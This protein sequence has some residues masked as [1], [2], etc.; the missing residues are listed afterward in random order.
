MSRP[1]F[2]VFFLYRSSSERRD[3]A[4]GP[5]AY[6]LCGLDLAREYGL[7]PITDFDRI[8]KVESRSGARIDRWVNRLW[9][10]LGGYGGFWWKVWA[11]RDLIARADVVVSQVDTVGIP[12]LWLMNWR[13]VPRR[14]IVYITVGLRAR[15]EAMS[16][17][18]R[19]K[20]IATAGRLIDSLVCFGYG[21]AQI[22]KQ[23]FSTGKPAVAFVPY[24]VEAL[25]PPEAWLADKWRG[26][27]YLSLG[28]DGNR[29]FDYL[30][31]LA[32]FLDRRVIA[33]TSSSDPVLF[34]R[35]GKL[36]RYD[37]APFELIVELIRGARAIILPVKENEYSGAT[38]ALM[39]CLALGKAV[40]VH[41][42]AAVL[43]GYGLKDGH[44]CVFLGQD[45]RDSLSTTAGQLAD[46]FLL[47]LVG[48]NAKS[49]AID[50]RS[51]AAEILRLAIQAAQ[52]R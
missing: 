37:P 2:K 1:E 49:A 5:E 9:R 47:A 28:N 19:K 32:D 4:G 12:L 50:Y 8:G 18:L 40:F 38:T 46:D 20:F 21:E 42:T 33:V 23:I 34:S 24:G 44:N 43:E 11:D 31:K 45:S 10:L 7:D 6:K 26:D 48:A 22:M 15:L 52:H 30:A 27:Y 51:T 36:T 35:P 41:P 39:Q 17:R 25:N 16:P 3:L 14:P 29:D 13:L